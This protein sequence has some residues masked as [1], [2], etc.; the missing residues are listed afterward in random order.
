MVADILLMLQLQI[1]PPF[2]KSDPQNKTRYQVHVFLHGLPH[3]CH[4]FSKIR[5]TFKMLPERL[6]S[7][8][9]FGWVCVA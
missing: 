9:I 8:P 6:R 1:R 4:M 5:P 7:S 2:H 3:E